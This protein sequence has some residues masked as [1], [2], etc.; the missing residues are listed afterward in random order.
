MVVIGVSLV[1]SIMNDSTGVRKVLSIGI[2]LFV[3]QFAVF[4][5]PATSQ[6]I[7]G[8]EELDYTA[9]SFLKAHPY[10]AG[11]IATYAIGTVSLFVTGVLV[12]LNRLRRAV[13]G[14]IIAFLPFVYGIFFQ[15]YDSL[16]ELTISEVYHLF[17]ILGFPVLIVTFA[18]A[19]LRYD[20]GRET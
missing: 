11:T 8:I 16:Y 5:Y 1:R 10:L 20:I 14:A 2:F 3:V 4:L 6:V 9:L 17:I 12:Y 19:L 13:V 18:T 15:P 7:W